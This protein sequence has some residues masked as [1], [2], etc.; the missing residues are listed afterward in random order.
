MLCR[1]IIEKIEQCFPPVYA[2]EWD[3]VGLLVGSP[4]REVN[5]VMTALDA[6]E[7][8]VDQA[9]RAGVQLLV[10]HHPMIFRGVKQITDRDFTGRKILKL[11]EHKIACY[12]MHTN[13]DVMGMAEKLAGMLGLLEQ[14]V[15]ME[16]APSGQSPSVIKEKQGIGRVGRLPESMTLEA[17]GA[18]VK[19]TLELPYV[20]V[21]GETGRQV[22]IAAVSSGSGKSMIPYAL[23]KQADVLITGDMGHHEALDAKEQGLCIIDAGHYGTEKLFSGFMKNWFAGEFPGLD[24]LMAEQREVFRIL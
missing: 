2:E 21:S 15:L 4:D 11:A 9:I 10:T 24:C 6:T 19:K 17:C 5:R 14:Q 1:H 7:E 13:F 3:N 23:E 8:V 22:E 16:V 18:F 20:L 12:A